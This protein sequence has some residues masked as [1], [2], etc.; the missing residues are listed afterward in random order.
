MSA[1]I[2]L[3]LFTVREELGKDF[4]GTLEKIASIGYSGVEFAGYGGLKADELKNLLDRLNLKAAGSHVGIEQLENEM[5]KVIEYNK[6]IENKYLVI[7]YKKYDSYDEFI[8][9]AKLFNDLGEKCQE[10]GI[11]LCYHNHYWELDKFDGKI[12]LDIIYDNSSK[13]YLQS[14]IDTYWVKYA[15][16]D[17]VN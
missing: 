1:R 17:P 4:Q 15:G 10:E 9:I 8:E 12:G 7:P 2:G 11:I 14:E 3:Q 5:E 16:I 13:D 6:I